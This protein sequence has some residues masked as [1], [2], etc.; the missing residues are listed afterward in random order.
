MRGQISSTTED[1]GFSLPDVELK[2]I[3]SCLMK[4]SLRILLHNFNALIY[5]GKVEVSVN[6]CIISIQH[7]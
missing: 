6:L 4:Y 1:Y 3:T 2:S 7:V 5:L